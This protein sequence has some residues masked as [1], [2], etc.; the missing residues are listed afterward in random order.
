MLQ[1]DNVLKDMAKYL[2]RVARWVQ[3]GTDVRSK[4][5]KCYKHKQFYSRSPGTGSICIIVN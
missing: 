1:D 5:K 3:Q 2:K 4:I